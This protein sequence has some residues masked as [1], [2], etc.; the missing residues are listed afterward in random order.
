MDKNIKEITDEELVDEAGQTVIGTLG[1][2]SAQRYQ[3]EMM[4]RL[5]D[6][7][8]KLDDSTTRYSKILIDLTILLFITAF[9]QTIISL[10]PIS[11][12]WL[13]WLIYTTLVIYCIYFTARRLQ[14]NS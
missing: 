2:L 12:T 14:K 3:V 4:R 6:S 10:I 1:G 7:I 9:L 13:D 5:K 11:K 8:E